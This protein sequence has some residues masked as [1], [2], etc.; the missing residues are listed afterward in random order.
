MKKASGNYLFGHNRK[1]SRANGLNMAAYWLFWPNHTLSMETLRT[2]IN[3]SLIHQDE[4]S[5]LI[6]DLDEIRT[7]W[8]GKIETT[9]K[10]ISAGL[11]KGTESETMSQPSQAH[12]FHGIEMPSDLPTGGMMGIQQEI[13]RYRSLTLMEFQSC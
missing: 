13:L 9:I 5:K 8:S 4:K 12:V 7:T 11:E 6:E 10:S 3:Q 2:Q 1:K